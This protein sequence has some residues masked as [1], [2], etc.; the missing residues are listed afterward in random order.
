MDSESDELILTFA[1]GDEEDQSC[2]RIKDVEPLASLGS[3]SSNIKELVGKF[4]NLEVSFT[5]SVSHH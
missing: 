3:L 4:S 5:G 2:D 1:D